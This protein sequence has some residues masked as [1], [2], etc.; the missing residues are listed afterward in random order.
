MEDKIRIG[1]ALRNDINEIGGVYLCVDSGGGIS[2]A[3]LALRA[4]PIGPFAI[5]LSD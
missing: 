5:V 4:D 1:R 3:A 2:S